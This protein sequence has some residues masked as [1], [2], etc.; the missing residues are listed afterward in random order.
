MPVLRTEAH[1]SIIHPVP[2]VS[3]SMRRQQSSFSKTTEGARADS[4]NCDDDATNEVLPDDFDRTDDTY[5]WSTPKPKKHSSDITS[6]PSMHLIPHSFHEMSATTVR[7]LSFPVADFQSSQDK[8]SDGT[9]K[10]DSPS[11]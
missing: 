11:K 4:I 2:K 3:L 5:E 9:S 6:P 10:H 1:L 7:K 8:P